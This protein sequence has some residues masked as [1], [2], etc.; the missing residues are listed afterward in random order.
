MIEIKKLAALKNRSN[1][2]LSQVEKC[3]PIDAVAYD[4]VSRSGLTRSDIQDK[5]DKIKDCCSVVELKAE[6]EKS[7]EGILEQKLKVSN[8]NFCKQHAVCAVCADRSQTRRRAR[9]NEAIKDQASMVKDGKRYAYILTYTIT[10]SE[11]LSGRL[12]DLKDFRRKW[13]RMGQKRKKSH[14]GGEASKIKAGLSTIEIKRGENSQLWHVHAHE[15]LFT[16]K[17]LDYQV[18]DPMIK[19]ELHKKYGSRI[20]KEILSAAAMETATFR[21]EQVPVSKISRE[22]L[23]ATGGESISIDVSPMYHVPKNVSMKKQRKLS[24]MTFEQS[25]AYQAREVI[26]YMSKPWE[27]SPLDMLQIITDTYNKR[28]IATYG[29][30][31]GVPG[32]DYEIQNTVDSENYVLVWDRGKADYGNPVP[33]RYSEFKEEETETRKKMAIM[34]GE[35][36]R[37]RKHII[38]LNLVSGVSEQLDTLKLSFK[39]NVNRL[40]Q[41]YRNKVRRDVI[42]AEP[43]SCDNYNSVLA[44]GNFYVKCGHNE[45]FQQA[46]T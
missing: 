14:S 22:W 24:A 12:Q 16:D 13:R 5:I 15:L 4:F 2:L 29:E 35:Y 3:N 46:F 25:I 23:E 39:E 38:D 20:P 40:W 41:Y 21:G 37:A 30:F 6:Y 1:I 9:Y 28:M 26:K 32:D 27:N 7:P 11:D 45:M 44:L 34:L 8:G 17:P 43:A 18:Y 42:S 33:G 19:K 10:D 31:R 36:R